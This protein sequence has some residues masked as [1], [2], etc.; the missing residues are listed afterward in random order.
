MDA[1]TP[2]IITRAREDYL[3]A[4][5]E[6]SKF[7]QEIRSSDVAKKFGITRASVSRMMSK[8]KS[9][10][11][12]EKEKYGSVVLTESGYKLAVQIKNKHDIIITFLVEVLGVNVVTANKDACKMEHSIS[13]ETAEKLSNEISKLLCLKE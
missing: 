3:R 10:R 8:L 9:Y 1:N 6:L 11:L 5:Y 2:N 13:L 4:L 12:I 7:N